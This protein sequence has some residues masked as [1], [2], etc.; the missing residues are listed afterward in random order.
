MVALHHLS[1]TPPAVLPRSRPVVPIPPGLTSK[2]I[3]QLRAEAL[4]SQQSDN[5]STSNG[6][7]T[8]SSPITVTDSSSGAGSSYRRLHTEVESLVRQE[9][10]R[11]RTEGLVLEAPSEAP[12]SY[13]EG[14]S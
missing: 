12:P 3:A 2:E 14:D 13:S 5:R 8:A 1:P 7:R 6:S 9:M 11:L 10:Q 4:G